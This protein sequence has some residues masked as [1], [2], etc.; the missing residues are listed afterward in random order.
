MAEVELGIVADQALGERRR[1]GEEIPVVRRLCAGDPHALVLLHGGDDIEHRQL[2]RPRRVVE[3]ES[4]GD[5]R[6]AVVPGERKAFVAEQFHDLHQVP[7]RRPLAIGVKRSAGRR[8]RAVAVAAHVGTHD[9]EILGQRGGDLV[10]HDVGLRIAMNQ[11][12][13]RPVSA[14]PQVNLRAVDPEPLGIESLEH[15]TISKIV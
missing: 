7:G 14:R 8:F 4:V 15:S 5:P 2:L 11:Q 1:L 10:P 12:E 13:R 6:A 3:R 9:G